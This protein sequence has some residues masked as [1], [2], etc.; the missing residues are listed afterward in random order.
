[1]ELRDGTRLE[2]DWYIAAVPFERL[3]DL[4]PAAWTHDIPAFSVLKN[5]ETSPIVSVHLWYDRPIT[6]LPHAVLVDC[7]GQWLFNRG[8]VAEGEHY[9]QVV[10]S[11]ARRLRGAGHEEIQQRI[12]AELAGLFPGA[13]TASLVRGRVVTEHAATFSAVPGVDRF[14]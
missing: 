10:I 2:A 7:L 9:F 13:A 4:L 8:Q 5:L 11:A 1:L 3:I 14:R 12:V 6:E